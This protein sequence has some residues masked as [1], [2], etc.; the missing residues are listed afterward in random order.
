M[1]AK[2]PIRL[3]PD[4]FCSMSSTR[5]VSTPPEWDASLLQGSIVLIE[6]TLGWRETLWNCLRTQRN[7]STNA[8]TQTAQ[9]GDERTNRKATLLPSLDI[10]KA[11][12][13]QRMVAQS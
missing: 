1:W 5:S 8:W 7:V 12:S 11:V 4:G 2:W 13:A 3:K 6:Y 9:S 10:Q